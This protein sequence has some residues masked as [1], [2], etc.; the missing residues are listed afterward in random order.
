MVKQTLES[1][2]NKLCVA[3]IVRQS[4]KRRQPA[5]NERFSFVEARLEPV[6]FGEIQTQRG[7]EGSR[8]FVGD[9]I[10]MPQCALI[11]LECSARC[12]LMSCYKMCGNACVKIITPCVPRLFKQR[13]RFRRFAVDLHA[14][15][16]QLHH[17]IFEIE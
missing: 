11:P 4:I 13:E 9:G 16:A 8:A 6:G 1:G 2:A 15:R 10:G 5:M 3:T 12:R 7:N 17:W 14:G